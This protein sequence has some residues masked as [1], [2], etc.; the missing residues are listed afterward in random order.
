MKVNIKDLPLDER[1]REKM[2]AQ[3]ASA[4]SNAEL[5]AILIGSGNAEE[6][7]VG[8]MQRVMQDCQNSLN[9]LGRMTT[10]ELM[11]CYKGIGEAKAITILA[12]CE[13][14]NRR[15]REEVV[16]KRRIVN[17]RD[18]YEYFSDMGS[19]PLEECRVLLLRQNHGIIGQALISKGGIAGTAVDVR[20]VLRH[21]LV[22]RATGLV[23]C[24]NHPS[25]NLR[26]S[27]E[28]NQLTRRVADACRAVDILFV[29]H[30]IVADTGYYSYKEQ[31]KI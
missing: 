11:R 12:A 27:I 25:G 31:G 7:A 1:P 16:E 6:T 23:L 19:L 5:L 4:L 3:G 17:S 14:G 26:P 8:L 22:N 20:E 13:L 29:D 18:A 10:E 21:A 2:M 9:S 15:R 30:I 24:H 28:D